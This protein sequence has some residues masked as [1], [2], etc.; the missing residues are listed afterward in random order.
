[1]PS[2]CESGWLLLS[3]AAHLLGVAPTTLERWVRAGR[4]PN[5]LT[6]D[7]Q[8]VVRRVEVL[9]RVLRPDRGKP[10]EE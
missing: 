2:D 8:R 9:N 10:P 1:M 5:E 3:D 7:G 4:I 6:Q